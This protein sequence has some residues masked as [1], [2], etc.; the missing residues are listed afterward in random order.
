VAGASAKEVVERLKAR[1]VLAL[2]MDRTT[3]RAVT[4]LMV[5]SDDIH[6]AI[7]SIRKVAEELG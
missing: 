4:S 1:G 7:A 6:R 3:I 2:P 5:S